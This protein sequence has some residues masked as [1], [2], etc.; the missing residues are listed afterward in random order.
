MTTY[1]D[2]CNSHPEDTFNKTYHNTQYGFPLKDDNLLLG[3]FRLLAVCHVLVLLQVAPA[4]IV[5]GG[6]IEASPESLFPWK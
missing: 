2:Y 3:T 4:G 5:W 6:A 1:C